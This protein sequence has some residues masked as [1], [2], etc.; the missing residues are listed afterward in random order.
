M[1]S[2]VVTGVFC[3]LF[4]P[5]ALGFGLGWALRGR[6]GERTGDD[7]SSGSARRSQSGRV[8]DGGAERWLLGELDK[9]PFTTVLTPDQ[10]IE[11]KIHYAF[12]PETVAEAEPSTAA[13]ITEAPVPETPSTE[14]PVLYPAIPLFQHRE[15]DVPS[16]A[17]TMPS[18]EQPRATRVP[19]P[20]LP[21]P[22]ADRRSSVIPPIS[23]QLQRE[24][25]PA[26]LLLY[27]GAFLI[28]AAGIVYASYSWSDLTAGAKLGMLAAATLTFMASGLALLRFE[29]VLPAAETF[30][31]IGALLFPTNA[32]A[33]YSALAGSDASPGMAILLGS[34]ATMALYTALSLRPGGRA[35]RYGAVV[36]GFL[37]IAALPPALGV[38]GGWGMIL[39]TLV[40]AGI[41]ALTDRRDG[42]WR[43]FSSPLVRTSVAVLPLSTLAGSASITTEA[44]TIWTLP[45]S[46]AAATITTASFAHRWRSPIFTGACSVMA[47]ATAGVLI[48]TERGL[49][50]W[51]LVALGLSFV[52]VLAGERGPSLARTRS[53]RPLLHAEA[54]VLLVSGIGFAFLADRSW[55]LSLSLVAGVAVT[56]L[57]A[58]VWR[59]RWILLASG[60][61]TIAAYGTIGLYVDVDNTSTRQTLFMVP[62]PTLLAAVACWLDL[63]TT[64]DRRSWGVP[65]WVVAGV[66]AFG[67]TLEP[68]V[69]LV[70]PGDR[71]AMA[72]IA[73]LFAIGGLVA[74]WSLRTAMI[75]LAYGI[76]SAYAAG[77]TIAA[78][79]LSTVDC[80]PVALFASLVLLGISLGWHLYAI[81]DDKERDP[82]RWEGRVPEVG[83]FL[84]AGAASLLVMLGLALAY[85]SGILHRLDMEWIGRGT[86]IAYLAT[87]LTLAIVAG[88]IGYR[89]RHLPAPELA[90]DAEARSAQGQTPLL[91]VILAMLP[92]VTI[93]LSGFA[94]ALGLRMLTTDPVTWSLAGIGYGAVLLAL[95]TLGAR[96]QPITAFSRR[97]VQ[98]MHAG[99]LVLGAIAILLNLALTID[100]RPGT[101]AWV[102]TMLY[103]AIG[104]GLFVT[105]LLS[106]RSAF[107]YGAVGSMT[108]A[109][110]FAGQALDAGRFALGVSLLIF[111]WLLA[112]TSLILPATGPWRG[113]QAV[114][115]QSAFALPAVA[116][117][118][119]LTKGELPAPA[120]R[121]WQLLVLATLSLAG[122]LAIDAWRR[123]DAVRGVAASALGMMAL[124]LEIAVREPA[125]IQAYAVPL[126]LYL[127]ALGWTQRR[128]APLRDMLLGTAAAVLV[129]PTFLQALNG[130]G[131]QWVLLAGG[132]ALALFLIGL[133]L[134]L[135]VLIAAGIIAIS[136]IVLRM[137]AN[138]VNA[139]PSW[140][141]LLVVG[142]AL[143]AGGTVLVIWKD[144]LRAGLDNLRERWRAMG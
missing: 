124:W 132:E 5:L 92:D 99:G 28:V 48:A 100:S 115:R 141:I 7:V 123:Q 8:P 39:L 105:G 121:D 76:W 110:A 134:R 42:R 41:P 10:R 130:D 9:A 81:S 107:A 67:I 4:L 52:L 1:D 40:L 61:F 2:S 129:V 25:D 77:L 86:W 106:A 144:S 68:P 119:T 72:A 94:A 109:L 131:F 59:Q 56:A 126:A 20:A 14:E 87:F 89:T 6:R 65:V 57:I 88:V 21:S 113:Q 73:S 22:A 44:G 111:A 46:F 138:A 93:G 118:L 38:R 34:L 75:R 140:M 135:R 71:L 137:A 63:R 3:V 90:D 80:T 13:P 17:A 128:Q 51:A 23:R 19:E 49:R 84:I 43:R 27:L 96:R 116:I 103:A 120:D 142:L 18:P 32:V 127:L 74:A 122:I 37:A 133:G 31:A 66:C 85:I 104:L 62:L 83:V 50:D 16:L 139:L 108:L 54:L 12:G 69:S 78:T 98:H 136:V 70:M 114:W 36:A 112:G 33:A 58:I 11:L 79:P 97:F 35:Y 125:N 30:V 26:V 64:R 55:L 143:L 60:L 117:L 15:T 53:L 102:E 101:N 29:R 45:L 24:W 47:I 82:W 95:A 91:A